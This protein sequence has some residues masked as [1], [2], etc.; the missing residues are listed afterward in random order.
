[1][2]DS[3]FALYVRARFE[4]Y[5]EGHLQ[6]KGY[7]AFCPTYVVKRRLSDRVKAVSLPLFPNYVFCRFDLNRRLPILVTPGVNSIVGCGKVPQTVDEHEIQ[8]IHRITEAGAATQPWP[9]LTNGERVRIESGPLAGLTGIVLSTKS[10]DQLIISVSLLLRSV[11][12]EIDR[13]L[14]R[15]LR[16]EPK[17]SEVVFCGSAI[18]SRKQ[19]VRS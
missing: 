2:K 11:G 6:Q 17:S 8:A 10:Q 7:E 9:Y 18:S 3:W 14:V 1:M 4:K 5:V 15:P 13:S 12:V 19:H 16:E